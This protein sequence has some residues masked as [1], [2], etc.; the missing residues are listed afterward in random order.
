ME[1][2]RVVDKALNETDPLWG[3]CAVA[4]EK[5]KMDDSE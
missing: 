1:R 5:R 3:V 4:D 2:E